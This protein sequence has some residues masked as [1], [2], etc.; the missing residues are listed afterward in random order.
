MK[1]VRVGEKFIK[2]YLYWTKGQENRKTHARSETRNKTDGN[3]RSNK[4]AGEGRYEEEGA[5]D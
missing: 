2:N 1:G 3:R 4:A 5:L